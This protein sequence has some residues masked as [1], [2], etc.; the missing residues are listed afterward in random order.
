MKKTAKGISESLCYANH[1]KLT[2][3]VDKSTKMKIMR[4]LSRV[5]CGVIKYLRYIPSTII[6]RSLSLCS[7]ITVESL[8]WLEVLVDK[9]LSYEVLD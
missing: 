7:L 3:T 9:D 8:A 2:N 5:H 1:P 6:L 4:H